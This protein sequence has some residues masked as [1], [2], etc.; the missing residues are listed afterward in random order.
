MKILLSPAKSIQTNLTFPKVNFSVCSFLNES[1]KLVKKLQKYKAKKLSELF[2]VSDDIGELNYLRFQNWQKPLELK[3]ETIPSI[4][5]FSGEVYRG[6]EVKTLKEKQLDYLN[7]NLRILSGLYGLLKPYDLLY[8]YRLE[9]GTKLDISSKIKNLYQFWGDKITQQL[10]LEEQKVI[11]N[12]ASNEYFKAV[13]QKKI[14]AKIITPVFKEFKNGEY[15]VLM[16][17]AKNARGEMA[18]FCAIN[19][20][21]RPDDLKVFSNSGYE[22]MA[23]L[24]NDAEWVFVRS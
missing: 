22:Y 23:N 6:L 5:A 14:K 21:Q 24:S 16:T 10:N 4:F 7:E 1:E 18:R 8:P 9:M 3:D 20:I 2:H 13:N 12:L 17:Y 11:I 19:N 15:K